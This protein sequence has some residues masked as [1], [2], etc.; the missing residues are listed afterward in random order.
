V[1][2]FI[3]VNRGRG[4]PQLTVSHNLLVFSATVIVLLRVCANA[5]LAHRIL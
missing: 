5:A 3:S 1:Q 4:Y 2:A